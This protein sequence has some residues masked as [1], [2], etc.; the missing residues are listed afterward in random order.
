MRLRQRRGHS[1]VG[2]SARHG[3]RT[4]IRTMARRRCSAARAARTSTDTSRSS[5]GVRAAGSGVR[6]RRTRRVRSDAWTCSGAAR[7]RSLWRWR[8]GSGDESGSGRVAAS[9]PDV[10][11]PPSALEP[12]ACLPPVRACIVRTSRS[13]S[14]MASRRRKK[15]SCS[16]DTTVDL[17]R[18]PELSG[19]WRFELPESAIA[20]RMVES[21]WMFCMR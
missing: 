6:T 21:A 12:A 14:G 16:V 13:S 1:H 19:R 10:I 8:D 5:R 17:H 2:S 3:P 4:A 18:C 11:S 7:R 20:S 15:S 9:V